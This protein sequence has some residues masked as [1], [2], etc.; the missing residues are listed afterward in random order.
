MKN[1]ELQTTLDKKGFVFN[2]SE[3]SLYL[4]TTWK[5]HSQVPLTIPEIAA[6]VRLFAPAE[7]E[8]LSEEIRN[9]NVFARHSWENSFYVARAKELS[10]KTVIE[11]SREGDPDTIIEEAQKTANILEKV[12]LLST[13][14]GIDRKHFQHSL[15]IKPYIVNQFNIT[16]G[17]NY[18]Y[19]R[20]KSR[21]PSKV[22]G[23]IIDERFCRRFS[24]CKF[25]ELASFCTSSNPL[26]QRVANA[27]YW[28]VESRQ[29]PSLAV[30]C[31]KSS[32]ALESLLILDQNEPLR[33]NLSERTAFILSTDAEERKRISEVVSKFYDERSKVVHGHGTSILPQIVEN[34]D[35]L[36]TSLC[37]SIAQ[38]RGLW[39]A[40]T[41]LRNWC[42]DRKWGKPSEFGFPLLRTYL[43]KA[44]TIPM[45]QGK[46][47]TAETAM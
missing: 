6:R 4:Q 3:H 18:Q 40:E 17:K 42:E 29:D 28:I 21:P 27:V 33:K 15:G 10:N 24:R 43:R 7:A 44:I 32:I 20:S 35:I 23:V 41:D 45:K 37:L 14:L 39:K 26:A 12:L 38:N 19:L 34:I 31:V 30:A 47:K 5:F 36:S 16:I 9:R 46:M 1:K 22:E 13:I 11:V 8:K 2:S 25:Q